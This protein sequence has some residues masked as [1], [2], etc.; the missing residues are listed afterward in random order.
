MQGGWSSLANLGVR[1]GESVAFAIRG[2]CM[3]VLGNGESVCVQR[4]R[5]YVPG[6]VIIVRRRD[7]WNAHRFLGYAPSLHGF[8]ALTQADDAAERDPA[9]LASAIVGRARC[10]VSIS[11]RLAALGKY[12]HALI[13]RLTKVER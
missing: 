8:V 4:Q 9:A 7:H 12:G 1:R 11:D 13:R 2:D 5:F 6:D 10:K 3:P